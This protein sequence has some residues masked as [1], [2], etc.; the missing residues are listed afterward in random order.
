M[1]GDFDKEKKKK[2]RKTDDVQETLAC[3][4]A[5]SSALLSTAHAKLTQ[6]HL[7]NYASEPK[8][9]RFGHV[10]QYLHSDKCKKRI[11]TLGQNNNTVQLYVL[12]FVIKNVPAESSKRVGFKAGVPPIVAPF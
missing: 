1:K 12:H 5:F 11:F 2:K 10:Q 6:T 3:P 7:R 4:C 9:T 8:M